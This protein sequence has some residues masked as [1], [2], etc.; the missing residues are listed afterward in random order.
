MITSLLIMTI[1]L[2]PLVLAINVLKIYKGSQ[3]G[4]ALLLFMMSICF[5]QI[6]IGVLYLKGIVP[7]HIILLLFQIFRIGPTFIVPITFYIAYLIMH[8]HS[9]NFKGTL[10]YQFIVSLLNKN[11]MVL[12]GVWS[13]FVYFINWTPLGIEG[14]RVVNVK[15]S[16]VSLYFPIYG[17]FHYLYL[18]HITMFVFLLILIFIISRGIQNV[19]LKNF[20]G[21]FSF[22]A[23]LLFT[24]GM[25]NFIPGTGAIVS[26]I[27]VIL[28]SSFIIFS[29]VK[30]NILMTINY[31][32]LIERQKKLD[33][34]GGLTSSLVHEVKNNLQVIKGYSKMLTRST[35][36]SESKNMASM[37]QSAAQGLEDLTNN[38]SV[39]I[40]NKI[41]Q[42]RMADLN[43]IIE[44]A[45]EIT[46]EIV[47]KNRVN[48][49][50]EKKYRSLN[51]Y[52]SETFI[53]Q[54]FINLIKNSSESIDADE[55]VRN[56]KIDTFVMGDQIIIDISDTGH[57]I[58][59]SEWESIFDPF[60]SSKDT[61]MGVGLPFVRKVIF[62][63]RGEIKVYDSSSKGTTF[64]IIL[65][66]YEFSE[67]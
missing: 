56:I 24:T 38:Y 23:F 34:S 19:Y 20:L 47:R 61:G 35:S 36:L 17:E 52:V 31:N 49:S 30:M 29:F 11:L 16:D 42:F 65:P 4:F 41:I 40:S 48:V 57:G 46:S 60:I 53:K 66:Q 10:Y 55:K 13:M 7:E 5:W 2:I 39:Y 45:I 63:H 26:S 9:P 67:I 50:F 6:D 58:Q 1:G 3:L 33:Y 25:V 32:K 14:L 27:G 8:K 62:E 12:F 21:T 22:C 18:I 54:V 51:T 59:V 43:K 28:F 37:I 64:R 15:Y 44:E